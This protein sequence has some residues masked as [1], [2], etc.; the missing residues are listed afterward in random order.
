[1]PLPRQK[2]DGSGGAPVLDLLRA[3][4]KL[5][6]VEE[7]TEPYTVTRKSDGAEFTK[8]PGFNCTI[9]VVDDGEDGSAN[10]TRFFETFRYKQDK[11]GNWFNKENSKLGQLTLVVKG[12]KFFDDPSIPDLTVDDLENFEMFARLKPRK[13]P[14]S[15]KILGTTIDWETMK[16]IPK[17]V[18]VA[19]AEEAED[20]GEEVF[21]DIPF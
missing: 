15:G 12:P 14:T 3:R 7:H 13:D 5:F 17:V 18:A 10:G 1:M 16:A 20:D 9:E 2:D 21:D 4:V 19:D 11:D 6:D 8:D